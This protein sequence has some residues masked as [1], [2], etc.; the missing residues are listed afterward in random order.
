MHM[1]I[2]SLHTH[3]HTHTTYLFVYMLT[4]LIGELSFCFA[5]KKE[6]SAPG[7]VDKLVTQI[8]KNVQVGRQ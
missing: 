7:F 3:T 1:D 4:Y 8:I 6:E 2:H 5:G